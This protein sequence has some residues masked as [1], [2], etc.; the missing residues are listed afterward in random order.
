MTPS[1]DLAPQAKTESPVPAPAASETKPAKR[2]RRSKRL[3]KLN[4]AGVPRVKYRPG[5]KTKAQLAAL[6]RWET[7]RKNGTDKGYKS[8]QRSRYGVPNGMRRAEAHALRAEAAKKA[9]AFVEELY[10]GQVVVPDSDEDKAKLALKE[11]VIIALSPGNQ[12]Y[13]ISAAAKV[14]EFTKAKPVQKQ[15]VKI[16]TAE[17]WLASVIA[18]AGK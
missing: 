10:E 6:K 1:E 18:D 5:Y 3:P 17:Q 16:S 13:K 12:S 15:D 4:G 11:L 14:L 9:E 8:P 7:R 2:K